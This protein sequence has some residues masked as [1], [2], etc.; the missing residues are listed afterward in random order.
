MHNLQETDIS[1]ESLM[2][3]ILSS[4]LLPLEPKHTLDTKENVRL[5]LIHTKLFC[6]ILAVFK[7]KYKADK[8]PS[9]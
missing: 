4:L 1:Q 3:T 5:H 8:A 2:K 7:C 9:L 6:H